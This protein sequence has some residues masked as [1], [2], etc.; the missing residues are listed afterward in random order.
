MKDST[1]LIAI[2]AIVLGFLAGVYLERGHSSSPLR[3]S[4][5]E[6]D[7]G[8]TRLDTWTGQIV[9]W[10]TTAAKGITFKEPS[11]ISLQGK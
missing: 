6:S 10:P 8:Y 11:D 5:N 7:T 4:M 1:P 3:Y 2:A 9:Q